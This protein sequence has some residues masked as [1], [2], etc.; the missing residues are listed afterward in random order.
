MN[1]KFLSI[2]VLSSLIICGESLAAREML[3][4]GSYVDEYGD[5]HSSKYENEDI[6][7]PWND[8]LI[9]NDPFAPWNDP[10]MQ[11][12]PFAPWN[13]PMADERDTNIYLRD[14]GERDAEYYWH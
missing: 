12:D 8:P 5:I 9:Q 10:L 14:S 4:D 11:D 13:D 3:S 1:L 6:T 7:A 2:T